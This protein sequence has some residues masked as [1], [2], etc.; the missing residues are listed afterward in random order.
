VDALPG[1]ASFV[2]RVS[3]QDTSGLTG[4]VERVRTGERH[5]FQDAAALVRLI[6]ALVEQERAAEASASEEHGDA[7]P[8]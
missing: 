7:P 5:R 8:E 1:L 4:T 3:R 2:V 6:E